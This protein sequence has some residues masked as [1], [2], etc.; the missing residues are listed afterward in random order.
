MVLQEAPSHFKVCMRLWNVTF[1]EREKQK[2]A[3]KVIKVG[4][5]GVTPL[6]MPKVRTPGRASPQYPQ[7]PPNDT[8]LFQQ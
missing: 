8:V 5:L 3:V 2:K 1:K 4:T 7:T 6:N